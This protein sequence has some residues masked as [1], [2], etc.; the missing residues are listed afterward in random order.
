MWVM[1][2]FVTMARTLLVRE[3]VRKRLLALLDGERLILSSDWLADGGCALSPSRRIAW[4]RPS[5]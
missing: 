1:D 5:G 2:G 4:P 3:G